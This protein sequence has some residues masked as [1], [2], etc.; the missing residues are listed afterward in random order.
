MFYDKVPQG[1]ILKIRVMPNSSKCGIA[2]L[3]VNSTG[4]EYLKISLHALP[5]KGK[6]NKE[7]IAYLSKTLKQC[8]SSF[9]VISGETDRNKKILLSTEQS[10]IE[11]K[12]KSMGNA[13]DRTN[14]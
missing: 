12:L 10:D 7:L 1:W 6:A 14:H 13:D 3:I 11:E 5:E 9:S 2:G 8:K 4:E